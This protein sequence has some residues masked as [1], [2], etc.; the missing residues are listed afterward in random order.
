MLCPWIKENSVQFSSITQSYPIFVTPWTADCQASLSITNSWSLFKL[1]SIESVMQSTISPF[2]IPF[3][4]CL[5]SF[6][7]TGSFP[8]S[9][10]FTSGSQSIGASTSASVLPMN[11]QDWFPLGLTNW[12]P[13]Y[14]RDSQEFSPT[15]DMVKQKMVRVN[16][17]ILG[18]SE[19]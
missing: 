19:L 16:I 8:R 1:M 18:I 5:Q 9:Q 15:L 2:V 12:S 10:F 4:S 17:D 3:S 7:A 11:I 13:C 14:P 6:P